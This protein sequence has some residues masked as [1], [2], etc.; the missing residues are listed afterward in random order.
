MS[1]WWLECLMTQ[2][3]I[4]A[5]EAERREM[6]NRILCEAIASEFEIESKKAGE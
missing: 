4:E 1:E 5:L 3:E 2:S 6:Y